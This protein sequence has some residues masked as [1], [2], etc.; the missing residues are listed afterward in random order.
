MNEADLKALVA[1]W[2]SAMGH[3]GEDPEAAF[4]AINAQL[5]F[6]RR[7]NSDQRSLLDNA[8]AEINRLRAALEGC[9]Q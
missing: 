5:E 1:R 4:A 2:L 9:L 7:E 3:A 8:R 6:L